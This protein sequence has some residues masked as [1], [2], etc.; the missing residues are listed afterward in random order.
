M[1]TTWLMTMIAQIVRMTGQMATEADD[2]PP[3]H[4][5]CDDS[6]KDNNSAELLLPLVPQAEVPPEAGVAGVTDSNIATAAV[7]T[8]AVTDSVT[9]GIPQA[10]TAIESDPN[11]SILCIMDTKYG[12]R[13][14]SGLQSRKH[15]QDTSAA[16]EPRASVHRVRFSEKANRNNDGDKHHHLNALLN[17]ERSGLDG[18]SALKYVALTQ[19]N[20]KQGLERNGEA[21][22]NAV[23]SS[24]QGDEAT[25]WLENYQA[26][27]CQQSECS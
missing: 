3:L 17:C 25:I 20:L 6:D 21:M 9:A 7:T 23:L 10:E 18:F 22:A 19:Y 12:V 5:C 14:H 4:H 1:H 2:P 13:Q 16:K 11:K 15:P 27:I 24:T 8:A 26:K